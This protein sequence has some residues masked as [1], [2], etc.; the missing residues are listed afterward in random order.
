MYPDA[1]GVR[2]T[3]H[4]MADTLAGFGYA[5]L[6]PDVY[7]RDGDWQPFDMATVFSDPDERKRLFGM[8]E[9]LTPDMIAADAGAF[10]DFL[11]GRPEVT[12][13]PV[14]RVRLLHGRTDVADRRGP[15]PRA[16]R[17]R[18]L[19][20]RR[21]TGDGRRGQ[22]APARRPDD[23]HRLRRCRGERR[24]FTTEQAKILD[25]ALESGRRCPHHR[26]V[27]RRT[28]IRGTRQCAY[29]AR[30]AERHW[31]ALQRL[32]AEALPD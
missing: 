2:P 19:D 7:Y 23:G 5:V 10:F 16:R 1:G 15:P 12:G 13:R 24:I 27:S 31:L 14:R 3:F 8:I 25:K 17:R 20:P 26:D 21:W 4:E 18:R 11:D 30:A 32:F 9:G 29:D 22:P 28:R 6:L